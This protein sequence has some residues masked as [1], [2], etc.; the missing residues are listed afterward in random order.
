[1][2]VCEYDLVHYTAKISFA[3]SRIAANDIRDGLEH[4]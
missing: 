1:M 4:L 3:V 2:S